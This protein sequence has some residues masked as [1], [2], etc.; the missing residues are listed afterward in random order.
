MTRNGSKHTKYSKFCGSCRYKYDRISYKTIIILSIN[1]AQASSIAVPYV[2][3]IIDKTY[4]QHNWILQNVKVQPSNSV[5]T[6][7]TWIL[8]QATFVVQ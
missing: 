1:L 7:C 3:I 2:C 4:E 5:Y 6:I 8:R